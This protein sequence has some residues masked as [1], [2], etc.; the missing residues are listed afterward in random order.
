MSRF[1]SLVRK[2]LWAPIKTI[3]PKN[4]WLRVLIYALP[5]VLLLALFGPALEVVLKLL[6]LVARLLEPMLETTV[7]RVLLMLATVGVFGLLSFWLLRKRVRDMRAEAVLGRHLQATAALVGLDRGRS[8]ELFQK[9]ARYRGPRPGRYPHVVQDANLKL[10][11]LCLEAG[12]VDEAL[13]WLA[14][15]VEPGLPKELRRSLL[16]LRLEALRRQGEVLPATLRREAEQA[17][18]E[19]G[20]DVSMLTVLRDLAEAEGRVDDV[21]AWQERIAK[22]APRSTCVRE[23]QRLADLLEQ[24]GHRALDAGELEQARKLAKSLRK[25]Q[26]DDPAGRLLLGDVHRAAGELRKALRCYGD[27]RSP[28]GLDRIAELLAEHP[29]AIEPRELLANCPLQ[30]TLLLV[31]RELARAGEHERA[32]RAARLAAEALGPTP[33]VCAVLAE[34]LDLLGK[35]ESAARLREQTVA[36]LLTPPDVASARGAS[37]RG[38]SAR[39]AS[40]RGQDGAGGGT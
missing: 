24:A 11:R 13:G 26:P 39:G 35:Q 5:F 37:A 20:D 19:F 6:D 30:G 21:L 31:A 36:R 27:T 2:V 28:A 17:V 12:K 32:E 8:R 15:V 33:T 34:V 18:R 40:A 14:R 9:V 16:Q 38:A 3:L 25:L 7:G 29:G 23:R 10:G 1:F 22:H 4:P